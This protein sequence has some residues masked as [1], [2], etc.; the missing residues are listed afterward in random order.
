MIHLSG[1][2]GSYSVATLR[3]AIRNF[4]L[5]CLTPAIER[6]WVELHTSGRGSSTANITESGEKWL[7]SLCDLSNDQPEKIHLANG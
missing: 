4:K 5:D 7:R 2:N 1:A 3:S 6:G